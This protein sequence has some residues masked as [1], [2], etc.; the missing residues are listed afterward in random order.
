MNKM[1]A[2]P[3]FSKQFAKPERI[4]SRGPNKVTL[5]LPMID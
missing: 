3:Q 4:I 5:V 2:F 1:L